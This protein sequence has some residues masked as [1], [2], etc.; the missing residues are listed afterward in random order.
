[1]R[2]T[3]TQKCGQPTWRLRWNTKIISLF[4]AVPTTRRWFSYGGL[5]TS[6]SPSRL[7]EDNRHEGQAH[8]I[9]PGTVAGVTLR[10]S[11]SSSHSP[12]NQRTIAYPR[13]ILWNKNAHANENYMSVSI[14]AMPRVIAACKYTLQIHGGTTSMSTFRVIPP[15]KFLRIKFF[16]FL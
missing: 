6:L 7:S 16:G 14:K 11:A 15:L 4:Y 3:G 1:M 8:T 9:E 12:A 13:A 2:L 10:C 5:I